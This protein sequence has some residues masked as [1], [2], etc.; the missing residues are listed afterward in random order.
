M[1]RIEENSEKEQQE[2]A[3]T[4][5]AEK[6]A[7]LRRCAAGEVEMGVPAG[8]SPSSMGSKQFI[9]P[10]GVDDIVGR[11]RGY[12]KMGGCTPKD[13]GTS[14]EEIEKLIDEALIHEA[15]QTEDPSE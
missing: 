1:E 2:A 7:Y 13:L 5:A 9:S 3:R 8:L 14:K 15:W 11:L 10:L 12:I 4:A 6:L